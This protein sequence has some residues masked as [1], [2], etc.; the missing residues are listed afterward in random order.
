MTDDYRRQSG[1]PERPIGIRAAVLR[2]IAVHAREEWPNECCGLLIGTPCSIEAAHRARNLHDSP[3]RYLVRP[4]DQVAAI[5][6]ARAQALEVVGA[7]HSHPAG[8]PRP[9]PTDREEAQP[10]DLIYLIA[11]LRRLRRRAR[12]RSRRRRFRSAGVVRPGDN[13]RHRGFSRR[14]LFRHA[15]GTLEVDGHWIAAWRLV[16]GN[17]VQAPLVRVT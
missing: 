15:V 6:R 13:A 14:A 17:F 11:G 12:G 8:R 16:G 5:R 9:S 3:T 10:S 7:Y 2:E 1:P 4:E